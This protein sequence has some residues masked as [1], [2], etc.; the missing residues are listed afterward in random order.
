MLLM[1]IATPE[2]TTRPRQKTPHQTFHRSPSSSKAHPGITS[3]ITEQTISSSLHREGNRCAGPN[4]VQ[5]YG[6]RQAAP[7]WVN[8]V[9]SFAEAL[10]RRAPR[11]ARSSCKAIQARLGHGDIRTTLQRTDTYLKAMTRPPLKPWTMRSRTTRGQKP[12]RRSS[13]SI[14]PC[15]SPQ[16]GRGLIGGGR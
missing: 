12:H 14:V 15:G 5:G 3:S 6:S 10:A 4:S 16:L 9:R 2:D 7:P 11:R 8:P 1:W 13:S